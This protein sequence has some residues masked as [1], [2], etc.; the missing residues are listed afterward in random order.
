MADNGG[1]NPDLDKV[2]FTKNVPVDGKKLIMNI[3]SYNNGPEKVAVSEES[4]DGTKTYPVK[5]MTI[6]QLFA[7]ANAVRDAQKNRPQTPPPAQTPPPQAVP[8]GWNPSSGTEE[9]KFDEDIPF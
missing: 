6:P 9:P 4:R 2:L 5:R 7:V 8:A 1:Y 3:V